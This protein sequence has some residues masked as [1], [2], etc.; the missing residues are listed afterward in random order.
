MRFTPADRDWA[1]KFAIKVRDRMNELE[2][3][4]SECAK[5][6]GVTQVEISNIVHFKVVPTIIT[7]KKLS[8]ALCCKPSDLIDF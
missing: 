2:L 4:Q 8:V 3:S 5:R 6:S 7:V 1:A